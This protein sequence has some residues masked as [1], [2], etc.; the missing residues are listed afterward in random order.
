MPSEL[1]LA[2]PRPGGFPRHLA[3]AAVLVWAALLAVLCG[4]ALLGE[5]HS[6]YP[7]FAEAAGRWLAGA[8][9]YPP[10]G[11]PYRYSPLATV[12]FV[13][14]RWLPGDLGG[15]AWRLVN[16]VVLL[17]GFF[18]WA[19]AVL[20]GPP[21]RGALGLLLLLLVPLTAGS[22]NNAQSNALVLG[23]VLAGV[24]GVA[25]PGGG[26]R[27]VLAGCCLAGACL[28]KLYPV[29]VALLL[30]VGPPRR[31]LGWFLA[32]LLVGLALPFLL[33]S[34]GYVAEQYA[35]WWQHLLSQDRQGLDREYWYRDLR[36][37]CAEVGVPL[38]E[39]GFRVL[40]VLGGMA[41]AGLCLAARR[42]GWPVRRRLTLLTALGCFWM[43]VLGP[44]TESATYAL[45]APTAAWA[46]LG[47]W[48]GRHPLVGGL[49]LAGYGLLV[50]AALAAWFPGSRQFQALGVQPLGGLVLLAGVLAA[51][52]HD[53]RQRNK[54]AP[55]VP[56][57]TGGASGWESARGAS[58]PPSVTS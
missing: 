19:R 48:R 20:P 23:L 16:A 22:L 30:A 26:W 34:P 50:V 21:S 15:V 18:W 11:E 47:P 43:T 12:L 54:E 27:P 8:E 17:A 39:D 24:A 10:E 45:L 32:A 40:Q 58:G 14:F 5:R 6:V 52:W 57:G 49:V 1:T 41:A 25:E 36:L 7:I 37:L 35:G 51:E 28:F 3:P 44:A 53:L 13:P 56:G 31:F 46:L 2:A 9:L 33:Q 38:A 55:P 42:A 29:A 4:R